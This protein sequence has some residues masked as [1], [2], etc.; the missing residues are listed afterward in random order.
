MGILENI[1]KFFKRN[2]E[3]VSEA[4]V[5]TTLPQLSF[6]E[7]VNSRRALKYTALY[8][9]I[10]LLSENIAS[11]PKI[12]SVKDSGGLK[13]LPDDPITFLLHKP[14]NY[15]NGFD[16]WFTVNAWLQGW[17]NAYAFI[18]R[19]S[20]YPVALHLIHPSECQVRLVMGEKMYKVQ[21]YD[22][23]RT[24]LN[25]IHSS[26]DMLHFMLVTYDGIKGVNPI[27]E[28]AMAI[29]K[30]ISQQ[31][32]SKEFY[33]RGGNIRA[34]I[35]TDKSLSDAEYQQ[36]TKHYAQTAQNFETPILEYGMQYK[37]I[38]V[39]PLAAQ[40]V[41]SETFSIQDIARIL[42]IPPHMLA[43]L[44][45]ATFSNIEHQTIQFV[46]YTL[47]P[48]CKRLEVELENKLFVDNR[49]SVKF[50]LDGLLRGDTAARMSY[51][52][53][54]VL[55]GWMSPNEARRKENM[56]PVKGLDYY[57]RPLNSEKMSADG[58]KEENKE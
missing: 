55:D 33:D 48:I 42:N 12:V 17:G 24:F 25:G 16:F 9:G 50:V 15:I 26:E 51:Y 54:A 47:R 49:H 29:G 18:E 5:S 53:N 10:R 23:S 2:A 28:N 1:K 21:V 38:G 19:N 40:L 37:S 14:N 57:N 11:L 45:H 27:I 46:Q 32:F 3:P 39:N 52:H 8:A 31:K 30:G 58:S 20:G 36:F 13:D 56:E 7:G 35:E 4:P 44:S 34:V 22:T 6:S 43:E 41:Q